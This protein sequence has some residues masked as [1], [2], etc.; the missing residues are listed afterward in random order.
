MNIAVI[1]GGLAGLVAAW[2]LSQRH[3]VTL[4]ERHAQ[5]GFVT[6][7]VAV[8]GPDGAALRVDVPLRVFYPGY[9]PTLMRLY[10]ADCIHGECSFSPTHVRFGAFSITPPRSLSSERISGSELIRPSRG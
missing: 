1:G 4:F 6:S 8:P 2:L 9:Y 10:Q 5:P 7:S 3:A